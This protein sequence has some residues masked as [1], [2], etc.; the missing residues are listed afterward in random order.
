[1]HRRDH[2]CSVGTADHRRLFALG[3]FELGKSCGRAIPTDQWEWR[4]LQL[5]FATSDSRK[6][7]V[8]RPFVV[9]RFVLKP[10][11]AQICPCRIVPFNQRD[12]LGA[13]PFL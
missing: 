2:Q 11:S 3:G 10:V 12:L 9:R 4:N 5:P 8:S 13:V 6:H 1:L 7:S